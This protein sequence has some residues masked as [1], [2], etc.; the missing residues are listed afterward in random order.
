MPDEPRIGFFTGRQV[1]RTPDGLIGQTGLGYVINQLVERFPGL[2][3]AAV[4]AG[5]AVEGRHNEPVVLD[6][7][8]WLPLPPMPSFARGWPHTA[9]CRRVL[10][11]LEAQS[12]VVLVQLPFQAPLALLRPQTPRVYHVFHD[13][14]AVARS[15]TRYD[16]V[17]VLPAIAYANVVDRIQ[18]HLIRRSDSRV[19]A[20]GRALLDHYG[21][22]G[23]AVVS[24]SLSTADL[25]SVTRARGAPPP[26]RLVFVGYLRPEKGL[27]VLLR[28]FE[29]LRP[30]IDLELEII[31]PGDPAALGP[32]V[33]AALHAGE[34]R[35]D[36]RLL[37]PRTFGPELFQH[38]AD[39]DLM[40][41]PSRSEGTPRVLV[42]ARAFGCP[43]VATTVGGIPT[44][45][46][47]GVDGLMV[48]PD[49]A[50]ALAAAIRRVLVDPGLH[51]ELAR[52]GEKRAAETTIER[53][54]DVL[55]EELRRLAPA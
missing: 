20:N 39:A 26:H 19:V 40:V 16:G 12:D 46:E 11:Q 7:D 51:T 28:A 35:G 34:Q 42:E 52:N 45:I 36:I 29:Q 6:P 31:G 22:G 49:D 14:L 30:S 4:D 9:A 2:R 13:V 33:V 1:V 17:R 27:D 10:R 44:S 41:L 53:F 37:G 23:Q 5:A 21:G 8:R 47:E 38:Y 3:L 55:A 18:G 54:A 24:S 15:Q 43:T 48:P 32:D 50:D 25:G